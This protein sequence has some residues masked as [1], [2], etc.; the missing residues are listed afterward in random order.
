MKIITLYIN[1]INSGRE[2]RIYFS[3][4]EVYRAIPTFIVSTVDKLAG[5][6]LNRRLKIYSVED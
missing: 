5:I 1:V 6:S 3:D 2:F 4:E